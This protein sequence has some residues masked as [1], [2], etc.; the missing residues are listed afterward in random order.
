[1]RIHF[2]A[3]G[4]IVWK[5]EDEGYVI[6]NEANLTQVDNENLLANAQVMNVITRALCIWEYHRVC[7]L[8]T[9][10]KMWGKLIEAHEGT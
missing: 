8:E 5:V 9:A 10:H 2:K 3:M 4:G 7:K 1:M 6:L